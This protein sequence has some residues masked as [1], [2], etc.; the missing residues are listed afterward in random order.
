MGRQAVGPPAIDNHVPNGF[1]EFCEHFGEEATVCLQPRLVVTLLGS[2]KAWN[3]ELSEGIYAAR[4]VDGIGRPR[5]VK[6]W[7]AIPRIVEMLGI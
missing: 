1:P 2:G 4:S 6:A 3:W 5:R 7:I